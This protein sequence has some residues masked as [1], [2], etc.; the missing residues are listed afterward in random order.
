LERCS[1]ITSP[2]SSIFDPGAKDRGEHRQAAGAVAEAVKLKQQSR[3]RVKTSG[4]AFVPHTVPLPSGI[5]L[6]VEPTY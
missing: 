1:L 3:Q 4:F 2:K 6:G 5:V